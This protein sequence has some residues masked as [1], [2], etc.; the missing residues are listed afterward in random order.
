MRSELRKYKQFVEP[1]TSFFEECIAVTGRDEDFLVIDDLVDAVTWYMQN[2][3]R[4][5]VG[6]VEIISYFRRKGFKSTQRRIERERR[7]GFVGITLETYRDD[8]LP[9]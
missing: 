6:K 7:R 5:T 1:L 2:E 3:G 4:Y 8:S 9:F